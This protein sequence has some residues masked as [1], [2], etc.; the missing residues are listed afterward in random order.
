MTEITFIED[1]TK[2]YQELLQ[3]G[4]TRENISYAGTE[5]RYLFEQYHYEYEEAD[6]PTVISVWE[7]GYCGCESGDF[8]DDI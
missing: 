2:I 1:F 8:D 4:L 3:G 7:C 6:K 5:L